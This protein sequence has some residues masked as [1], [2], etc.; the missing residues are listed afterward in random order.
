MEASF[1]L[2]TPPPTREKGK[3]QAEQA[4]FG[5]TSPESLPFS[6][7]NPQHL[8]GVGNLDSS[9][10]SY[11]LSPLYE[12]SRSFGPFTS[13]IKPSTSGRSTSDPCVFTGLTL[14][15]IPFLKPHTDLPP[16]LPPL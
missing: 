12:K 7:D 15:E 9:L 11:S 1:Q 16:L 4:F 10:G 13:P 5:F 6:P 3:R 2:E 8:W 14:N